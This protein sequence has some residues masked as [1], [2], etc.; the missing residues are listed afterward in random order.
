MPIAVLATSRCATSSP[1][2]NVNLAA[3]NYHFG[4]KDELIAELFVTRSLALNR[5]RLRELKAAE[6]AGGG[7][8]DISDILRAL[9]GPTLRGCLG[10]NNQRS[11]A[12]R[13]MIR[14]SIESV[15]PIRRIRNRE[16]DHL[17][18]FVAA[19]RRSLP[20][21]QRGRTLL[22][23]AFRARHGA[24]DR[25]RQRAADEIVGRK[26]RRRRRRGDHRARGRGRGDGVDGG[27]DRKIPNRSWWPQDA[28]R[29]TLISRAGAYSNFR[30]LPSLPANTCNAASWQRPA[31][32]DFIFTL[33]ARGHC[34]KPFISK[35]SPDSS[36][37]P[38]N[39]PSSTKSAAT[40]D[41]RDD[42]PDPDTAN[43]K[44]ARVPREEHGA[45]PR[46]PPT[47]LETRSSSKRGGYRERE[48]L[49]ARVETELGHACRAGGSSSQ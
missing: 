17:R 7:T 36:G 24:T 4:S 48:D 37:M 29:A 19:M 28:R 49:A 13:F 18:K 43:L 16:I 45:E 11:T 14:V 44:P 34:R 38:I 40:V 12:A 30:G 2:P 35:P 22:G 31:M 20:D 9:V 21:S 32:T 10:P 23:P 41:G 6:D 47:V 26:M 15:P 33:V 1:R 46:L 25:A 5:E 42:P 27:S 8:A 39:N 3:V